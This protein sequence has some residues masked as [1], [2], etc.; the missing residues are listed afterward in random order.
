MIMRNDQDKYSTHDLWFAALLKI[1]GFPL[2]GV[3]PNG[4]GRA[5]FEFEDS[6]ERKQLLIDLVNKKLLIEPLSFVDAMK[7]LKALSYG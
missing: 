3:Q 1:K 6:P 7:S 5:L 4:N 2:L